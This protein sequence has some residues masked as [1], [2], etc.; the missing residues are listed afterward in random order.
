MFGSNDR[1]DAVAFMGD[2]GND[3][4]LSV[5]VPFA[6]SRPQKLLVGDF[7]HEL[8][9]DEMEEDVPKRKNRT[10]ARVGRHGRSLASRS[11]TFNKTIPDVDE[12]NW[13]YMK[14]RFSN[15][16]LEL[17][18]KSQ[19]NIKTLERKLQERPDFQ[20]SGFTVDDTF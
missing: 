10:K 15:V 9:V 20:Q 8:E 5:S 12:K 1:D 7:P 19:V 4:R 14:I 17:Q 2:V 16:L 11:G 3:V 18:R 13:L 6:H